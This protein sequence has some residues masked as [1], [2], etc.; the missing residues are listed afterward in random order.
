MDKRED[1]LIRL[2]LMIALIALICVLVPMLLAAR[3]NFPSAD[4][5]ANSAETHFFYASTHS[6]SKV[7]AA[8]IEFTADTYMTW[9]G[10]FTGIFLMALQPA[11]FGE[12]RIGS[13]R[14]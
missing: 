5:F 4:D 6:L 11:I 14:R 9:Q 13:R 3:Y 10:S 12:G 7:F 2:T 1:R 8:A